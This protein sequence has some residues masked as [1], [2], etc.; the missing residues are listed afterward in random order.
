MND[1][2]ERVGLLLVGRKRPGFDQEWNRTMVER[3]VAALDEMGYGR[4]PQPTPVPDDD[5]VRAV[6]GRLRAAGA[7]VLVVLQPSLGSGQLALT[8][9]QEWAGPIVLWATPERAESDT[10]SSCSLVA[11]HLWGSTLRLSGRAFELVYGEPREPST[12]AD[13]QRAI[14]VA[15]LAARLGRVKIGLVGSHAPGFLSM[16]PD[17]FLMK[18]AIGA[19]LQVL[20]L[21]QFF[22][23]SRA[24]DGE[25]VRRDVDE[26]RALGLPMRDVEVEDLATNS[27][28]YLAMRDL[29]AEE[30]LDG[31]AVQ[32]WPEFA[33]IE[34]Q[35]PYLAFS[36]LAD[37]L[38]PIA[39]E[40]DVDGALTALTGKMLGAG[41]AFITDWLEHDAHAIHFWHP[42]IAPLQMCG[43]VGTANG[44][45]LGRHFN[46]QKPLV[47]NGALQVGRPV[48]IARL[49]RCEGE[50]RMT[51]FGGRS[52]TPKRALP[53]NQVAVEIETAPEQL[54]DELLHEGLPHH[55][56]VF[57]GDHTEAFRRAS[58][59]LGM[60][61]YGSSRG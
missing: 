12:R 40:G 17:G 39:L 5:A 46:I 20:S 8:V 51:A 44:P 57:F 37:T 16:A 58:R 36:R 21:P 27:R 55:L 61:W 38:Y 3:S 10:V 49:W 54:L 47:M 43:G 56:V 13:L 29:I 33:E 30:S 24:I 6:V 11:Q 32:C 34:G 25:R 7:D 31:L 60:H 53:G 45:S 35:W 50:Y 14:R 18:R 42:G 4:L 19:Q 48:T 59:M 41:P 22:A 9:S 15:H 52:V 1:A 2:V 28:F 23:R 26:V